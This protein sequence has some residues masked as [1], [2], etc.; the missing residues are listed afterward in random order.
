M[1]IVYSR[2]E[3]DHKFMETVS[4]NL[5]LSVQVFSK[6]EAAEGWLK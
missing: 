1:A 2:D 3:D 5:G 6:F 4:R